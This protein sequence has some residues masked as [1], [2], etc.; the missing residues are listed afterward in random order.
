[1]YRPLYST[2]RI[3]PQLP[4]AQIYPVR[5]FFHT[6]GVKFSGFPTHHQPPFTRLPFMLSRLADPP[7]GSFYAAMGLN[8]PGFR[9]AIR[10]FLCCHGVKFSGFPTPISPFT[11]LPFMLFRVAVPTISLFY[12]PGRLSF[13]GF[14]PTTSPLFP[15]LPLCFSVADPDTSPPAVYRLADSRPAGGVFWTVFDF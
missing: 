12:A 15:R 4:K 13:P 10:L 9:P 14:R 5:L 2:D 6:L 8:F 7:S 3:Y 1:M 11:R